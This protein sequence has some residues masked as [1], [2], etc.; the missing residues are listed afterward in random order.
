MFKCCSEL[1]QIFIVLG[2]FSVRTVENVNQLD[3]CGR[4]LETRKNRKLLSVYEFVCEMLK[5]S[6][7]L[8]LLPHV[9]L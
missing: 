3:E 2:H 9:K 6:H 8:Q 1:W 7:H 4:R 5:H